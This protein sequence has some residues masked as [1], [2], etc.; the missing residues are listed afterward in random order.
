MNPAA[1]LTFGGL[2]A[3]VLGQRALAG[4]G[5]G[6][7]ATWLGIGALLVALALRGL[8]WRAIASI[9]TSATTS[10]SANAAG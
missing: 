1:L 4:E 9:S 10:T 3:I 7:V 2:L 8:R 5:F 6:L